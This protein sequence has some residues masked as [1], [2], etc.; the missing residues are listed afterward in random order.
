MNQLRMFYREKGNK[1]EK[2]KH[3]E[4]I[5]LSYHVKR[6]IMLSEKKL[7]LPSKLT[8]PTKKR[9][10]TCPDRTSGYCI[11]DLRTAILRL[12]LLAVEKIP[13][14]RLSCLRG[15]TGTALRASKSVI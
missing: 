12:K 5:E 9:T 11:Q 13:M 15:G 3:E 7:I 14:K 10:A 4:F 6:Q 8:R 1:K 2:K